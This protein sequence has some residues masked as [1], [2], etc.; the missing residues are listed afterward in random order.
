MALVIIDRQLD[1]QVNQSGATVLR[2]RFDSCHHYIT[3]QLT[4]TQFSKFLGINRLRQTATYACGAE[5]LIARRAY[6]SVLRMAVRYYGLKHEGRQRS[7]M[8]D[9]APG[10]VGMC[11][12]PPWKQRDRAVVARKAHNLE[13]VGSTPTPATNSSKYQAGC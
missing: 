9:V 10:S 13:V 6:G 11:T 7:Y 12:I 5:E 1:E 2:C 4:V 3:E 8:Q